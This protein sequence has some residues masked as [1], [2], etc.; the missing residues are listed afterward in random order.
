MSSAPSKL[1]I[2]DRDGVIN[3]DSDAYIRTPDE[4]RPIPGS[5]EAIATLGAHDFAVVVL[6]N[7]SGIGRGLF[8]EETLEAIHSKMRESVARAGGA[9]SGIYYCPHRPEEACHCRKPAPGLLEQIAADFGRSLTGTPVIGDKL[10]DVQAALAVD[11]RPI[12]VRTGHGEATAAKLG[13]LGIEIYADLAE[14]AARL[15]AE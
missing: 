15:V 8:S 14:A 12:L 5:L 1:V 4:W 11:A 6:S 2:L 10:T 7:Q 3:F 9:L 13:N